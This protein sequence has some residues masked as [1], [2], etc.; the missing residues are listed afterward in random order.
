M[1]DAGNQAQLPVLRCDAGNQAQLPPF[2][3]DACLPAVFRYHLLDIRFDDGFKLW[4][5]AKPYQ[6]LV[7][8]IEGVTGVVAH[9]LVLGRAAAVMLAR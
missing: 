1:R 2:H 8:Q 5:E 4:G 9:G 7:E 6:D 3:T